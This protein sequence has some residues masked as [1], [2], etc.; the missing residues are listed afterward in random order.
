MRKITLLLFGIFACWHTSMAQSSDWTLGVGGTAFDFAVPAKRSLS[1]S[2]WNWGVYLTATKRVHP[3]IQIA[4]SF[5]A[6]EIRNFSDLFPNQLQTTGRTSSSLQG[7]IAGQ[8]HPLTDKKFDPYVTLGGGGNYLRRSLYGMLEGGIGINYWI[9]EAVALNVQAGYNYMFDFEDYMHYRGGFRFGLAKPV[10]TDADGIPDKKDAC[11]NDKGLKQFAGCPDTDGDGIK[12]SE[13]ACPQD[14]GTKEFKGC[15]D[16]DGDK[17]VDKDDACPDTPGLAALQG[18]PDKDGDGIADKDDACP[19]QAG[20]A[21]LQGCPDKDGDGIADKDDRCPDAAGKADLKGCPD[22]DGDTIADIDDKC[23]DVAGVVEEQGCPRKAP[24]EEELAIIAKKINFA[25]GKATILKTSFPQLDELA[26]LL[27]KYPEAKISI[28]G[29]TDNIGNAVANKKL[30]QQRA[31][32]IKK[33]LVSKKVGAD[34]ITAIGYGS[35][36]PAD[37]STDVKAANKTKEQQA[38]NRRVEIHSKK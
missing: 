34:R 13:D 21:T 14:A 17:V 16:K 6:V 30:S 5:A 36:R 32:A 38:A 29:H 26:I 25:T 20:L 18:C 31:D 9:D 27:Q 33:Y 7:S 37:G 23:P 11:P 3:M 28:E 2:D 24:K 12:D 1:V 19:D 4:P 10:D 15:P 35:E 22:K 8:F